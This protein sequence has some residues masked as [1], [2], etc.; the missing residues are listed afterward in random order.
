MR[1][2]PAD[3]AR[4]AAR[5]AEIYRPAVEET[6][7]SFELVAPD[8]EEMSQRMAATAQRTP[9][10]VAEDE[11]DRVIG[12]AYSSEH[13]ARA[14]Y[15][16]SVDLAVYVDPSAQ[17][18]GVGKSLYENLLPILVRQGFVNAY[19]GVC[20]PNAASVGLH[21]AVGMRLI[22]VYER[23]GYKFDH[24]WDVAWYGLRLAE[25]VGRP[26]EP[27]PFPELAA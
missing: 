20:L 16:W 21:E 17:G 10:L 2:R 1:V 18:R 24:W 13:R 19:A 27:I 8:A 11:T 4:D 12:Y 26:A 23:V 22:G 5:V 15:R 9:W 14:G 6:H 25:P 7:V 3:P